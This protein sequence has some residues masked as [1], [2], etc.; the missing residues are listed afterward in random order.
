MPLL[1]ASVSGTTLSAPRRIS[2]SAGICRRLSACG[3]I[4]KPT[5]LPSGRSF[6]AQRCPG[7]RRSRLALLPTLSVISSFTS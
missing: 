4:P 5:P 1:P 6:M 2:Q 3:A 7:I